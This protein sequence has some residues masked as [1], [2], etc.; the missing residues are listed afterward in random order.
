MNA[1]ERKDGRAAIAKLRAGDRAG[2][3]EIMRRLVKEP[4]RGVFA[5]CST[6]QLVLAFMDFRCERLN[7]EVLQA[8]VCVARQKASDLQRTKDS[9]RGEA[10]DYPTCVTVK[11]AQGRAIRAALDPDAKDAWKGSGAGGRIVARRP[12]EELA[13]QETARSAKAR[14]GLLDEGRILDVDPD[15]V[16]EEG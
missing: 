9:W 7:G 4:Q 15:P 13:A 5:A 16:R 3:L 1:I 8:H 2:A 6:A 10:G 14:V 11:C 12:R